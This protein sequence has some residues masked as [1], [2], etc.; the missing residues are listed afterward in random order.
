[1]AKKDKNNMIILIIFAI[2]IIGFFMWKGGGASS[3]TQ[4]QAA[5]QQSNNDGFSYNVGIH[6]SP[7]TVCTGESLT[8][9]I[10]SNMPAASCTIYGDTGNGYKN[11]KTVSL[12]NNG[13]YSEVTSLDTIGVATMKVICVKDGHY[14]TSNEATL[15]VQ[16][17]AQQDQNQNQPSSCTDTD[18]GNKEYLAGKVTVGSPAITYMDNCIGS[19]AVREF[20]C[21]GFGL[22]QDEV[23]NCDFGCSQTENGGYCD[24]YNPEP[25]QQLSPCAQGCVDVNLM[26]VHFTTGSCQAYNSGGALSMA[27]VCA[28]AN[29]VYVNVQACGPN[30]APVS[31]ICCCR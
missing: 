19:A 13:D 24:T 8:A 21:D 27:A 4:M 28:N 29:G 23:I 16:L 30:E 7:N 6:F 1:M 11:I 3:Y 15:T 22:L 25:L 2:A 18:G 12:N 5:A 31:S 9:Y 14:S 26:G 20:F 17:C 10:E